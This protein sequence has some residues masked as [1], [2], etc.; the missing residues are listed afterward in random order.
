MSFLVELRLSCACG[1]SGTDL[2]RVCLL[3]KRS[4]LNPKPST[5]NP[6]PVFVCSRSYQGG[7]QGGG[8]ATAPNGGTGSTDE[9]LGPIHGTRYS[10]KSV[11][12]TGTM[13]SHYTL[14]LESFW[15]ERPC[16]TWEKEHVRARAT[17]TLTW[18]KGT[19]GW[20]ALG[21][22]ILKKKKSYKLSQKS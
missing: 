15:K 21:R 11:P 18:Y 10:E 5:L 4:N 2:F 9:N 8:A 20:R 22:H 17:V 12:R 13:S 16:P 14:T 7:V 19:I 1:Y 6:K 3:K